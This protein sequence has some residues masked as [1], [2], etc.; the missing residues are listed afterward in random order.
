MMSN[1]ILFLMVAAAALVLPSACMTRGTGSDEPPCCDAAVSDA[2]PAWD[3]AG[4][5]STMKLPPPQ[6]APLG[7]A[8]VGSVDCASG[9]CAD[10][11]C[12]DTACDVPCYACNLAGSLG[13]C[14]GLDGVADLS[15]SAPCSGARVCAIDTAGA[16]SCKLREG[17]VCAES[18]ECAGGA[19][20]TYHP[21]AD[22]DGYGAIGSSTALSRCDAAPNPPGGLVERAGDCCDADPGAKP[23]V[24]AYST[25][26]NRC[27]SFDWNC[28]GGE[29]REAGQTCPSTAAQPLAC[30]QACLFSFKGTV[31]AVYVQA[32]R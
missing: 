4:R 2:A 16:A 25:S 1:P 20:R 13:T 22:G 12:C 3:G 32:C 8:C 7:A 28:S 10:G 18:A 17:K 27:G 11:V 15:A 26:R 23:S 24:V 21:D 31:T 5:E 14:A 9:F 29:D 6:R 19:C 30:G